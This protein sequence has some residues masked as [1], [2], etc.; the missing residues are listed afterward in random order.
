MLAATPIG[1]PEDASGRLVTALSVAPV[2]AAEDTTRLR[3]LADRLG[4]TLAGKVVSYYEG[5]EEERGPGLLR[6]LRASLGM[7]VLLITHNLGVVSRMADRVVVMYAG[8]VLEQAPTAELLASP[9]HPYTIGLLGAVP[10]PRG[11]TGA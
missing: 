7:S 2:I 8:H 4:V 6:D 10:Q 9:A 3:R 5:V 1:R 11:R